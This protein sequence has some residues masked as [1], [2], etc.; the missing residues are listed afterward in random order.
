MRTFGRGL[1]LGPVI[2]QNSDQAQH[3]IGRLLARVPGAFV[4]IDIP[5]DTGLVDWLQSAGLSQVDCTVSM[6]NGRIPRPE[7]G[8]QPFAVIT[9]ALG[10][11]VVTGQAA[12]S[13][14]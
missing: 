12:A 3:L 9:Q 11:S 14:Q 10:S 7:Q 4:R 2:A 6:S 13:N 5:D 8:V 1:C